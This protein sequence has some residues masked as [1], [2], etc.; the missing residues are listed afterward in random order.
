LSLLTHLSPSDIEHL[1]S[2]GKDAQ[3]ARKEFILKDDQE[4]VWKHLKTLKD[5][6]I[7]IVLDNGKFFSG[8][9]RPD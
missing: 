4:K 8:H 5:R 6:R 2:V 3:E 7:D 9:L 1:Q